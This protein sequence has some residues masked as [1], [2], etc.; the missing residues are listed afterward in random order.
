MS[1]AV[2]LVLVVLVVVVLVAGAAAYGPILQGFAA[3]VND[4]SRG[5]TADDIFAVAAITVVQAQGQG[6]AS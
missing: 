5:A 3:P 6:D 4:L 2:A 1:A